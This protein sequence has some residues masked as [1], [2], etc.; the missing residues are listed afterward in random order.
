MPS[1]KQIG[2][3]LKSFEIFNQSTTATI[4]VMDNEELDD[5]NYSVNSSS[6]TILVSHGNTGP[7]AADSYLN[8]D[9]G[10]PFN[11]SSQLKNRDSNLASGQGK[12]K[13]PPFS[14]KSKKYDYQ[15]NKINP[16]TKCLECNDSAEPFAHIKLVS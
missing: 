12:A 14:A 6:S 10:Y 11:F 1:D 15:I 2:E 7:N 5:N 8:Y 13:L 3:I 16:E 4:F 9:F